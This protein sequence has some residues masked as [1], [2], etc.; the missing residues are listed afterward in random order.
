[1]QLL[2]MSW[3]QV[4]ALSKD[5][6]VVFPIAALEQH[7][8]HMPLFTDSLLL[9]EVI[10]RA[11]ERLADRVLFAPL[12]WLGNSDHHLDFAGTLSAAPRTY[13]DLLETLMENFIQH[14]FKRLAFVNGHG[15]NIV[16]SQQA[17]FELRQKHRQRS[18]LLLLAATYWGLGG[19]PHE[20]DPSI[21][22]Q[23]MGHACE[24]ETS[25]V[26][27]IA[28]HLVGDLSKV[29][30]VEFGSAFEPAS[31]GWITKDRTE[32][33]HIG[34]PR[35]ATAEKGETLF[36]VFSDDVVRLLERVVAWDGRGWNG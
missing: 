11:S 22:Q 35:F 26:L 16:P 13:L 2:E 23:R 25:M 9:G 29:E 15:G 5:T 17:V 24:W 19:Q 33:G 20:V 10:R 30:P 18:D 14:G 28:P 32:P 1:M 27:R 34:D 12:T 8:R 36:R 7:G 3:P 6:P 31:R 4:A 21:K